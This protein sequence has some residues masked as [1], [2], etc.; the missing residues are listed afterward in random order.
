M[1]QILWFE[2][3][4]PEDAPVLG[5]KNASLGTLFGAGLPVPPGFAVSADCYRKALADNGLTGQIDALVAAVDPRDTGVGG[6]GRAA[7][8]GADRLAGD[9]RRPGG[10]DRGGVRAAGL[11]VR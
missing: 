5:G 10:G 2:N 6:G 3:Y 9:D 8:P 1:A 7:R 11:A 4:Q